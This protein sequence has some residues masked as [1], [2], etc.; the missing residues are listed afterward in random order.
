MKTDKRTR[1][2]RKARTAKT[3]KVVERQAGAQT[4]ALFSPFALSLFLS[5]S[6][7]FSDLIVGL[8]GNGRFATCFVPVFDVSRCFSLSSFSLSS[9]SEC[10]LGSWAI[11]I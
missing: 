9:S 3:T 5:L 10:M 11:A 1:K 2:T 7:L 4:C 6:Y 8:D